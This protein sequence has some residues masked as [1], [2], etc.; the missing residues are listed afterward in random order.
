LL[1]WEIVAYSGSVFVALGI[2]NKM[3]MRHI[4]TSGLSDSIQYFSTLSHYA[5][6]Q[7]KWTKTTWKI[8]DETIARGRNRSMKAELVNDDQNFAELIKGM[9]FQRIFIKHKIFVLIFCTIFVCNM[10]I[11]RRNEQDMIKHVNWSSYKVPIFVPD[12]N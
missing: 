9:I 3:R 8:F 11:L 5:E 10:S 12:F 1:Q 4:F 6:L 2:Q 7:S